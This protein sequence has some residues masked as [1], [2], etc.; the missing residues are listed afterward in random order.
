MIVSKIPPESYLNDYQATNTNPNKTYIHNIH[1]KTMPSGDTQ[2]KLEI[3]K[4]ALE[5][6][7]L[8]WETFL[9][10]EDQRGDAMYEMI[11]KGVL[12]SKKQGNYK[13]RTGIRGICTPAR[14]LE[15]G[16][17]ATPLYFTN[18]TQAEKV[19]RFYKEN[20]QKV[21]VIKQ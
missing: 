14:D 18:R 5:D 6:G 7:V 2:S 19:A 10:L 9:Q 13:V 11:E 8:D 21:K 17:E 16:P 4:G 1:I 3:F 20:G 12:T 15:Y